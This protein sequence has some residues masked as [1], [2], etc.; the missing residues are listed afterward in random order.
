[1]IASTIMGGLDYGNMIRSHQKH[2]LLW[3]D[4]EQSPNDVQKITG[5]VKKMIGTETNLFMYGL[6]PLSPKQRVQMIDEALLKHPD[7]DVLIIDGARDLIMNINNPEESTEIITK[8]MKWSFDYNIHIAIV[9]HTNSGSDKVRGHIGTE[10]ENKAETVIKIT[11]SEDDIRY[12]IISEVYGRGRTF[13][14]FKFYIDDNGIP[15]IGDFIPMDTGN[16]QTYS[17]DNCPY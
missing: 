2:E 16:K 9:I 5:R 11:K 8:I 17:S 15:V 7:I 14:E 12:S 6:R 3:I 13:E 1:M 4:T 10:V